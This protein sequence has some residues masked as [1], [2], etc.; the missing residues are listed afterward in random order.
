M[1]AEKK[2][3]KEAAGADAREPSAGKDAGPGAVTREQAASDAQVRGERRRWILIHPDANAST[4]VFVGVNGMAFSITRNEPA[5]VPE[6]VIG[7]LRNATVCRVE[8][9]GDGR[10]RMTRTKVPRF[11]FNVADRRE[12]LSGMVGG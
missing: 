8:T 5:Y 11:A 7:V 1:T 3:E 9:S 12:D 2:L 10:S 4:P 6:S